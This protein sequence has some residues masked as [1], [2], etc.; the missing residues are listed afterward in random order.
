LPFL[1]PR[2]WVLPL[3]TLLLVN[4]TM[5]VMTAL[6]AMLCLYSYKSKNYLIIISGVVALFMAASALLL[7]LIPK[8]S[9]FSDS[10]RIMAWKE[11]W[12]LLGFQVT[13][14]GFGYV[15]DIVRENT[16]PERWTLLSN[17]QRMG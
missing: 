11:L 15:P 1:K 8:A 9:Y 4:S 6:I 10:H 3:A 12:R 16:F 7:G 13:G 14:Q 17:A 5:P 2:F